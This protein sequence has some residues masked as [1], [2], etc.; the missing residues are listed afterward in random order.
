MISWISKT[1]FIPKSSF[2]LSQSGFFSTAKD[3]VI[4]IMKET[5]LIMERM[6][7]GERE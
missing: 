5:P 2:F 4:L 6:R 1:N 3:K 7:G